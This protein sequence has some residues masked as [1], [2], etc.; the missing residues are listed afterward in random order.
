L[1]PVVY[2]AEPVTPPVVLVAASLT[3]IDPAA[4]TVAYLEREF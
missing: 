3:V 4:K 2:L 1:V